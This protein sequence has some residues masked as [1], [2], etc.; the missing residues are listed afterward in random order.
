MWFSMQQE[1]WFAFAEKLFAKIDGACSEVHLIVFRKKAVSFISVLFLL[2]VVLVF[3]KIHYSSIGIWDAIF[4]TLDDLK[5]SAKIL[6]GDP[7]LIRVDEWRILSPYLLSQAA[8]NFPSENYTFGPGK[9][10]VLLDLPARHFSNFFEPQNWGFFVLDV[11]RGFS[12]LWNYAVF[13][14]IISSF[15]LLMLLTK[16]NFGLSVF[17]SLFLFF[18][19]FF[20]WWCLATVGV[21]VTAFNCI[22]ISF[23]YL[24][25]SKKPGVIVAAAAFLLLF[26]FNF[27]LTFYPAFQVPLGLLMIALLIGYVCEYFSIKSFFRFQS[28]RICLL[29]AV[30]LGVC[31]VAYFLYSDLKSTI[32]LTM[33]TAYPGKR[34][35][36]GG[37]FGLDRLF[38]GFYGLFFNEKK[39]LWGNVCE[40]SSFIFYFPVIIVA[41]GVNCFRKKCDPLQI[42]LSVYL[43]VMGFFIVQGF[44]PFLAKI[45]LLSFVPSYRGIIGLG[46]GSIL[47]TVAFLNSKSTVFSLNPQTSVFSEARFGVKHAAMEDTSKLAPKFFNAAVNIFL[48][49]LFFACLAG[50]GVFL[51]GKAPGFFKQWQICIIG[52]FFSLTVCLLLNHKTRLFCLMAFLIAFLSTYFVYPVSQGLGFISDKKMYKCVRNIVEKDPQANWM[53]Y[54]V[55]IQ[56]GFIEATGANVFNGTKFIPDMQSMKILDPLGKNSFIYNRFAHV[57]VLNRPEIDKVDFRLFFQDCYG[58]GISPFSDK[59]NELK[60][61]YLLMPD[62]PTYYSVE[63]GTKRGIVPVYKN[64][65][66]HFWILENIAR[67]R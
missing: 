36:I 66:D 63:E 62:D 22:L 23:I 47:L 58:I 49:I 13:G 20:Q 8:K 35:S 19:G 46:V 55:D 18:S 56:C 57:L 53:I 65:I 6:I 30:A 32:V 51:N 45:S 26:V 44:P 33:N 31:I 50:L 25:S 2:F 37:D 9:A 61:K 14:F 52:I 4:P 41:V 39:F 7:K 16:N 17:G 3:C 34:F 1:K 27:S 15:L 48:F 10:P 40:S 59:L 12:F 67:I 5:P 54:G 21:M 29:C 43:L 11:E 64:P 42:A 60:I 24:I 38:S 28:L